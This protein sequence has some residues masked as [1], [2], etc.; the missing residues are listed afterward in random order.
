MAR[1]TSGGP[2]GAGRKLLVPLGSRHPETP[3]AP[4][5]PQDPPLLIST[6][7]LAGVWSERGRPGRGRANLPRRREAQLE[8]HKDSRASLGPL[9]PLAPLLASCPGPGGLSG[10]RAPGP[11]S[12]DT[13]GS[14]AG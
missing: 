6:K 5:P 3:G 13:G 1:L 9:A 10:G 7:G 14:R 12:R 4:L 11:H 8:K 2:Q